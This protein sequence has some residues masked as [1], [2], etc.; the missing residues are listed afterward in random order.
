M[1]GECTNPYTSP[2]I[3]LDFGAPPKRDFP[4]KT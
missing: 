2:Y 3:T 1:P 4:I